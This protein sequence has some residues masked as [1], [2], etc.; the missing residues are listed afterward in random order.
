M[1][2]KKINPILLLTI[3]LFGIFMALYYMAEN[4]YYEYKEYNKMIVTEEAM[5][6]FENDVNEGK[7][8][9]IENYITPMKDYTNKVSDLGL[10][11]S[12]SLEKF[13]TKGIGS[14]FKVLGSLVTD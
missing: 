11:T 7:D 1:T 13:M 12:E 9:S 8:V 2:K 14:I 10:K 4:G 3:I 5:K 6:R